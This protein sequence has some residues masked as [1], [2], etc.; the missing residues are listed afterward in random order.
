MI[1]VQVKVA[2]GCH[3]DLN[4]LLSIEGSRVQENGSWLYRIP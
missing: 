1:A 4:P 2:G 3:P